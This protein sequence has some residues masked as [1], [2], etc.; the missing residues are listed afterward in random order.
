M[1]IITPWLTLAVV[2][3]PFV[4]SAEPIPGSPL[5]FPPKP[6]LDKPY[7]APKTPKYNYAEVL[8]KSYLFYHAQKSG[9]LPYQRL[10]WR[11][12]SCK[13]CVGDFGEDLSRAW[14]EAANTMKWGLPLGWATTQLA[15]NI[16]VFED[17]MNSVDELA[18]GLELLKWGAD[19]LVNAH[20]NDT[21]IVGQ[22]GVSALGPISKV[23]GWDVDFNYWGPPEEYEQWVPTGLP[24]KATYIT[25]DNPSSE[26]I[27]E[28]TAALASVSIV[29][30]KHNATY[31]DLLV[32]HAKRLYKFA[33]EHQG[34]Y[35]SSHQNAFQWATFWYP[36]TG[37]Q[38]ELA[39]GAAW[40]YAATNDAYYLEEAKKWY[41]SV[42]DSWLEYSWDEK[43]G[44]L[45]VLLYAITKDKTFYNNSMDYFNQ[46]LPGPSQIVKY[47]PRGLAY[48]EHWGSVGYSGNV[49]FLMM[50]F[51]KLIGYDQPEA[52]SMTTFAVQQIN[53]ALGD[54]GYS[55]V[56]GFGDNYPS[57]P[58]HK[59]SYNSY[60][61][62]PLR[63]APQDTVETDFSE[64]KTPQRFILYG[65]VEGGPNVDDSW[66][67]DRSNYE[68][69][70]VTQDYNAAWTGAIAGLIDFYGSSQ[71]EPYTDCELD[72]G[73]NHPNASTPPAWPENDCYHTC[74]KN[75]PRGEMKSSYSWTLLNAPEEQLPQHLDILYPGQGVIKAA[76]LEGKS[77]EE[78]TLARSMAAQKVHK[79]APNKEKSSAVQLSSIPLSV[80]LLLSV[81]I[82]FV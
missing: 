16:M 33:V 52:K 21:H 26:I 69:S 27:G 50:A 34:S 17:S 36:S 35:V 77:V 25:P 76:Y 40:L 38:D 55:W 73:W 71:F 9:V 5:K 11:S 7:T 62:Y 54:Y 2:T 60:I 72:L 30:R 29:W 56:V 28:Y 65:A 10:A 43:G 13:I 32:D 53:Y 1:Q 6:P 47:T 66:Y 22:L 79:V 64:S 14:Y 44:G 61:D 4:F 63:G 58:Y 18:E 68:Y 48:I 45:H 37:Y 57:K 8:H 12:D 67:D 23:I 81:A 49:A 82:Y 24:H 31:A 51:A 20:H 39:W 42:T 15:F 78:Y 41:A 46:F 3:L 74:N 59:A 75:C 19:Y 80:V 70:E